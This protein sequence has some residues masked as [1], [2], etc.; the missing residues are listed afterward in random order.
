MI[1]R[2]LIARASKSTS[3]ARKL[4]TNATGKT[5]EYVEYPSSFLAHAKTQKLNVFNIGVAFL[6]L[7]LSSQLVSYKQKNQALTD[8]NELLEERVGALEKLVLSL[9][10]TLPDPE[11]DTVEPTSSSAPKLLTE[12][13]AN[14]AP[15]ESE[16]SA[17]PAAKKPAMLI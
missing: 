2:T 9:G 1:N 11:S 10:G 8:Q 4:S 15:G 13:D 16:S 5:K 6:T 3:I 17:K 7:S 14:T 12:I